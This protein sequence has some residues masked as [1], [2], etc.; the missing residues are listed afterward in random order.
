[1]SKNVCP[2]CGSDLIFADWLYENTFFAY[3]DNEDCLANGPIADTKEEAIQAF[4]NPKYLL[5]Q[6]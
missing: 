4:C 3:C 2:Y 1:M 5:E 6:E